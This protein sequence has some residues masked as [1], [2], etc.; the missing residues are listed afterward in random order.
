VGASAREEID[1]IQPGRNYGWPCYEGDV[2]TPLYDEEPR[3]LEEYAKEGT[4]AAATPP[5]WSYPHGTGASVIA[6][7]VYD[8]T[9]YPA[10]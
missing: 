1:L 8:G 5:S 4:A 10:D 6:G 9:R 7:P 3:C 2:R